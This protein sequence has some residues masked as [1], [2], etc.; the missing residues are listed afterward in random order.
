MK[1][2]FIHAQFVTD[3]EQFAH[4]K[5]IKLTN[6]AKNALFINNKNRKKNI[7]DQGYFQVQL[8]RFPRNLTLL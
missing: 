3:Y 5:V 6:I 1:E 8:L 7:N 4:T 2:Q